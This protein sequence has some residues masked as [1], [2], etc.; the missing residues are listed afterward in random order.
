MSVARILAERDLKPHR[1]EGCIASNAQVFETK[2]ADVIGFCL[3]PRRT[4]RCLASMRRQ[5]SGRSIARIRCCHRRRIVQSDTGSIEYS[6]HG[7]LS[8]CAA[9]NTKSGQLLGKSPARPAM[10]E[11][12]TI[13]ANLV[14][15]QPSNEE[16]HV[17]A[18]N[19]SAHKIKRVEHFLAE[20][21]TFTCTSLTYPS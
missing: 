15:N 1:L 2:A 12:V 19:L 14:A 6:W 4:R 11:F 9:F 7:T 13:L 20:K 10:A 17:I 16:I 3:N 21:K 5:P 8:L 18:D